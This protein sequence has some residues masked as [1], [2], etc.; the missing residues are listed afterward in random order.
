MKKVL[1]V[2]EGVTEVFLLFKVLK[3]NMN[4]FV[5]KKVLENGNLKISKLDKLINLFFFN[6]ELEIYVFNLKGETILNNYIVELKQSREILEL[7]KVLFIMDADFQQG[8]ETGFERTKKALEDVKD[9]LNNEDLEVNYFITPNNKDDGM[10]ETLIMK[11]LNCQKIVNYM[12]EVILNVKETGE[13]EITNETKSKFM[14][15]AATQDPLKGTAP[16][17]LS[18]CYDKI[19]QENEEFEKI[20]RFILENI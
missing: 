15:V 10:T 16:S 2:C 4:L 18:S 1:F 9:K 13:A 7:N 19:N 14:M 3:K 8:T 6:K 12:D 20:K 11:S 17:F 5:N